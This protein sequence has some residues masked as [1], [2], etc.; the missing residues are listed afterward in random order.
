MA[1]LLEVRD[2]STRY[3]TAKGALRPFDQVSFD[4][5]PGETLALVGESGCGK[6]SLAKTVF[7]LQEADRGTIRLT[8]IDITRLRGRRLR[9]LRRRMQMVFQDPFAS[10]NPRLTVGRLLQEP[11]LVHRVGTPAEQRVAVLQ[12][13]DNVGLPATAAE[14]YPHAFSGGQ[15]QRIGLARALMLAPSLL[16]CDEPVSALDVSVQAQILNLLAE[17]QESRHLGMLFISHDLGVVRHMADRVIVMHLGRIVEIGPAA[18]IFARPAHPY[19]RALLDA[20]PVPDPALEASRQHN[21]L[22]GDLP[23]PMSPPTGCRFHTR[24]PVAV[25]RCR[26][27]EPLLAPMASGDPSRQVACWLA[28]TSSN[29]QEHPT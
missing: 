14:R 11:L 28:H 13:L 23:S 29:T 4:I 12:A 22:E 9:P 5:A 17:A 1:P 19:T 10:L 6:T 2:L 26:A 15:R 25:A 3:A 21:L 8:G 18:A 16:I 27:E 7:R 20:A 24:C